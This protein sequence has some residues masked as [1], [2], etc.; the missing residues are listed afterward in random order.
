VQPLPSPWRK[1]CSCIALCWLVAGIG[2]LPRTARSAIERPQPAPPKPDAADLEHRIPSV[3]IVRNPFAVTI[4]EA[5]T[6]LRGPA[7]AKTPELAVIA[8]AVGGR[9]SA[10]IR[11]G[12][13]AQ[14][15]A[16]GENVAGHRIRGIGLD[17]V[18]LDDGRTI[19]LMSN[20]EVN[21]PATQTDFPQIPSGVDSLPDV[22]GQR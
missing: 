19:P 9:P 2:T 12:A 14:F 8:L 7:P 21:R 4:S 11:V 20:T 6:Q 5:G 17:G 22:R 18:T 1:A 15:Y 10:I 16:P 3:R 13:S